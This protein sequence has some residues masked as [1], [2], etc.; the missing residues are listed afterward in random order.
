MEL[1]LW[2][3]AEAEDGTPDI[4]RA[5]T[6]KGQRQAKNMAAWL[7]TQLT[8]NT[9][10]IRI[11]V[12]PAKRTQQTA[13]AFRRTFETSIEIDTKTTVDRMYAMTEWPD[14][15]TTIVVGHQPTLGELAQ[16]LVPNLP[17]DLY[18]KKGAV[19]WFGHEKNL[20]GEIRP[21]LRTVMYPSML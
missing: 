7:K 19:W 3:H 18:F 5:L 10:D 11:I 2:R 8:G 6:D 16:L 21:I 15:E 17:N 4:E 20:Q 9:H 1:I 12:S 13:Q 14:G